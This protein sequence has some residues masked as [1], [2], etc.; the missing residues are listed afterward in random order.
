MA[1]PNLTNKKPSRFNLTNKP[2]GNFWFWVVL[3]LIFL[4]LSIQNSKY[5]LKNQKEITYS[6][7]FNIL[8]DNLQTHQIKKV[9]LTEGPENTVKGVFADQT[10]FRS[11]IPQHDEDLVKSIRENVE[12]F[13]VVPPELFWSQL[14]FQLIPFLGIFALIWFVSYRGSQMGN[15]VFSFG[16]SREI[17]R[18]HV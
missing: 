8:K 6:E 10:E 14:F 11:I 15:K 4:F 1:Q 2:S 17:G 7:F 18:A 16:K 5:T 13:S 3:V 9:E 12:N